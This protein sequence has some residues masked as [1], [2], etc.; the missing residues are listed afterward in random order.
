MVSTHD[1]TNAQPA[2]IAEDDPAEL[3]QD[4][5]IDKLLE[6]VHE[7][8]SFRLFAFFAITFGENATGY[9]FFMLS[10]LTMMS[11]Y[12]NCVFADSQLTEK[13][14]TYDNI[15]DGGKVISYEV[16]WDNMYSLHNWVEKLD[17]TCKPSWKLGLIGSMVFVGWFC[18]LP[19]LPRLSDMYGR[20]KI[21]IFGMFGDLL[22]FIAMYLANSFVLMLI[23]MFLF[24]CLTTIRLNISFVYLMEL[25]P[26]KYQSFYA[27]AFCTLDSMQ[28][29]LA[30]MYFWFISKHWFYF[31][32]IG[33]VMQIYNCITI[34]FIPES[35]RLLIEL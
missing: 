7:R 30:T 1:K 21:L 17:L 28:L 23:V 3:T 24:G 34:L 16:D 25:F 13:D 6:E 26:K 19:W 5:K 4:E 14:C 10:Y 11:K 8:P 32:I 33:L 22:L 2:A 20:K 31:T 15:C 9:W 27:S 29:F 12:K 18:T 35:P